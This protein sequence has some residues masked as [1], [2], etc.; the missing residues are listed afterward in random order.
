[1]EGKELY[2]I[3]AG[4]FGREVAW[5]AERINGQS[6]EWQIKGFIDDDQS[7]HGAM[8]GR[9]PVVG[10]C[11]YLLE[12]AHPAW[13]VCAI[14]NAQT[15][16]KVIEKIQGAPCISF[17]TLTDPGADISGSAEI[18]EGSIICAGAVITVDVRIGRHSHVNLDCT[19]GH[20]AVL[21]DFVTL[22]PSV[23]VSGQ[24]RIGECAEIGTG[25][26][27]IQGKSIGSRTVIGAGTVVINDIADGCT[28]VGS[29][30]RIVK[31]SANAGGVKLKDFLCEGR[32]EA[33]PAG[34]MRRGAA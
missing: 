1:M 7:L 16:R 18:G 12:L 5:L 33:V 4:G 9:Y 24:V 13:C 32:L 10:G 31:E 28:A 6:P 2:I 25:S 15:R 27:I 22:Y 21:E 17:A 23:N 19:I 8:C 30:A 11:G 29:P 34:M 14:G 26:N 20:D 3:G